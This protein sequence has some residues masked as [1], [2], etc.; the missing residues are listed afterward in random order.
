MGSGR[1]TADEGR[2]VMEQSSEFRKR[3]VVEA[4]ERV[5][6][7]GLVVKGFVY[8]FSLASI[9]WVFAWWMNS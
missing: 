2:G 3:L 8:G 5:L 7:T 1:P 4:R 9:W 6:R